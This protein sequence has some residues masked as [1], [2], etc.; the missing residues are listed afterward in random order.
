MATEADYLAKVFEDLSEENR[1]Y[2]AQAKTLREM[3]EVAL[4]HFAKKAGICLDV[5]KRLSDEQ[6]VEARQ[7][8]RDLRGG[9]DWSTGWTKGTDNE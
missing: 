1:E 4:L 9:S 8:S 3:A 2:G 5:Q 7:R 6:K